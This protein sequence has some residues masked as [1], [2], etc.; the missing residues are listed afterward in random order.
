[1]QSND[2]EG[3]NVHGTISATTW[4]NVVMLCIN[5]TVWLDNATRLTG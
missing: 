3:M 1:M 4:L 2:S 5:L